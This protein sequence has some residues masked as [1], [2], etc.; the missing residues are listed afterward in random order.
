MEVMDISPDSAAKLSEY[1]T[2]HFPQE[3]PAPVYALSP[4]SYN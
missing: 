4:F 2:K 3:A 1:L